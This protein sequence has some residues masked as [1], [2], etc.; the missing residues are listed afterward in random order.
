MG[1][2]LKAVQSQKVSQGLI[3]QVSILQMNSPE[4][5]NYIEELALENPMVE[6]EET[7]DIDREKEKLDQ[8]AWLAEFDEQNRMY[9]QREMD[10]SEQG[11]I[12]N[13][14]KNE[15]AH[16]SDIFRKKKQDRSFKIK[17]YK[18]GHQKHIGQK[19]IFQERIKTIPGNQSRS[20]PQK[21]PQRFRRNRPDSFAPHA[22]NH[23]PVQAEMQGHQHKS[24]KC[25]K[26]MKRSCQ[27]NPSGNRQKGKDFSGK[28]D[29][30]YH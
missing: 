4:L 12:F 29:S 1:I 11:D 8:L 7:H 3:Q 28:N 9:Y 2:E 21:Y 23:I 22:E 10:D 25:G 16:N 26:H 18:R 19:L 24:S 30:A 17:E 6:I 20:N 27:C 14:G 5:A 13:I 15:Q